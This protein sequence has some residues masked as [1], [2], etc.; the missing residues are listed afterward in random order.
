MSI[1]ANP[2]LKRTIV[3]Q[4]YQAPNV[5]S[6]LQ[7]SDG[8]LLVNSNGLCALDFG[9]PGMAGTLH[10]YG[11]A[12]GLSDSILALA[13]DRAGNLWIGTTSEGVLKLGV[14]DSHR[15]PRLTDLAA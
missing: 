8:K 1:V 13:E 7:T 11:K 15:T 10:C 6:L 3:A 9:A 2:V 14:V 5:A 4:K 12:T